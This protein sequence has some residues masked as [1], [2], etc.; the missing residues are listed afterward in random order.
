MDSFVWF[1]GAMSFVPQ[2]RKA[3]HGDAPLTLVFDRPAASP[4][5]EDW[6]SCFD[7]KVEQ[8][9]DA[10]VTAAFL[11]GDGGA[12]VRAVYEMPPNR[13]I[14]FRVR[15]GAVRARQFFLP[16]FPGSFKGKLYGM[17]AEPEAVARV[18]LSVTPGK[19]FRGA[20]L[21]RVYV[22]E[23]E[24]AGF[25]ADAPLVDEMGQ[26][27][28]ASWSTRTASVEDMR[29]RL[30]AEYRRAMETAPE[31]RGLS[32][33]GGYRQKTFE[34]TGWFRTQH[35]GQ[36]W[37]L[38]DPEGCAF[39]SNGVCYGTRMGEFG[40]Y[41]GMERLY[42]DAPSPEDPLYRGGFT[43]PREIA[44]YVKRHGETSRSGDWM[45]TP[46]RVNMMRV[47]GENWW[48]AW[49]VIATRR[50]RDWGINT[51]GVG[52]STSPTSGWRTSCGSPACPTP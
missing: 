1:E 21:Y 14:S 51:T 48:E 45:I 3:H 8:N 29:Q 10:L 11:P 6:W 15:V 26:M 5:Q 44:E 23:H 50:F 16:V 22:A 17:P 13:R 4:W 24:P 20:T 42:R 46:A 28:G 41:S 7:L 31:D 37:W 39:F 30:R 49:R 27:M 43:H 19:D 9:S 38:V 25:T 32:S 18:E 47:F 33:W 12:P 36:R 40:W 2:G 34:A 35:D 52:W